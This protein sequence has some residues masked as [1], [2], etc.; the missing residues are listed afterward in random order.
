MLA[1]FMPSACETV[2]GQIGASLD[3]TTFDSACTF[4]G[5][6]KNVAAKKGGIIFPRLDMEKEL[7]ELAAI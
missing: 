5:L 6:P 7:A 3:V 1:P 4:G 2:F